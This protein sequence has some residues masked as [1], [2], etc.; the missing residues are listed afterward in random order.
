MRNNKS[1]YLVGVLASILLAGCSDSDGSSS[2]IEPSSTSETLNTF[3]GD[4]IYMDT[5]EDEI[6]VV[7]TDKDSDNII[8]F[9]Y[10]N[11]VF[12]FHVANSI[13]DSELLGQAFEL[14]TLGMTYA[15]DGVYQA[16][17]AQEINFS[18]DGDVLTVTAPDIGF[19]GSSLVKTDDTL[20][21]DSLVGTH[22]NT[23]GES[24][25]IFADGSFVVNASC[26]ISGDMTRDGA[27][28]NIDHATAVSCT[29]PSLINDDYSGVVY[30][31]T[32]G[33]DTYVL[34]LLKNESGMIWTV[35]PKSD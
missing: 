18:F 17:D 33:D 23:S 4:G 14:N 19:D 11:G 21:L 29:N 32:D 3:D 10:E 8:L 34:S 30:T 22:T 20:P 5:V 9:R 26:T 6:V 2:S 12:E 25:T 16:N 31:Y 28:F 13:I 27:Y 7:D 1:I 15:T 24:W 35:V